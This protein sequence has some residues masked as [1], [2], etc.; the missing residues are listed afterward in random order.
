VHIWLPV[1]AATGGADYTI[2]L[3]ELEPCDIDEEAVS[4]CYFYCP[5]C[6]DT[7]SELVEIGPNSERDRSA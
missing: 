4:D 2:A 3:S 1:D 5:A 6:N 7:F